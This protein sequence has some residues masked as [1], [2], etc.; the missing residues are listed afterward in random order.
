[1]REKEV[2]S[3]CERKLARVKDLS[4]GKS[5]LDMGGSLVALKVSKMR[6]EGSLV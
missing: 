4:R 6:G 3:E 2:L 1:M 5:Y